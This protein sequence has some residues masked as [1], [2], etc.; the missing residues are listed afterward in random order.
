MANVWVKTLDG[1]V[2]RYERI[3]RLIAAKVPRKGWTV[4]AELGRGEPIEL[5]ALGRGGKP[6]DAARRLC[7]ELPQAAAAA[8]KGVTIAFVKTG[9][10]RWEGQ[11]STLATPAANVRPIPVAPPDETQRR[12]RGT[13]AS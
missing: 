11:W 13:G 3:T 8:G 7:N 1:Q 4:I 5:A 12:R 2:V 10:L 9:Y 6:K